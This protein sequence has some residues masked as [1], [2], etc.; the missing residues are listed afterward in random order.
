[1]SPSS[2]S[3]RV[4]GSGAGSSARAVASKA[5]TI[6]P[7]NAVAQRVIDRIAILPE[8]SGVELDA[9]LSPRPAGRKRPPRD[10]DRIVS[11]PGAPGARDPDSL[12][13]G[14]GPG[15]DLR[16]APDGRARESWNEP[17]L[18]GGEADAITP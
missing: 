11:D 15:P 7:G 14:L 9:R 8:R 17:G 18:V 16:P 4:P 1:M 10:R 3:G 6:S 5:A 2:V 12:L 13:R